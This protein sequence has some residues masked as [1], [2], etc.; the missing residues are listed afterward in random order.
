MS[1]GR[2]AA[3]VI[4]DGPTPNTVPGMVGRGPGWGP[5]AHLRGAPKVRPHDLRH[6]LARIWR[7]FRGERGRIGLIFGFILVD[8]TLGMAGPYLIGRGVD[9]IAG[10]TDA[11]ASPVLSALRTM[12]APAQALVLAAGALLAAYLG[13]AVM[14]TL[15]G[16]IMAGVSQR[17]V[18]GMRRDLFSKMQRLPL[19]FYDLRPH[20]DIMSRLTND[21]D[22]V[23]VTVS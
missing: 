17:M 1:D 13:G 22:A 10:M 15:E 3:R 6:A 21:V 4:P 19:A 5:G 8:A 12:V 20:G 18:R 7:A 23:S 16:W 11:S 2:A 14:Q 9:A